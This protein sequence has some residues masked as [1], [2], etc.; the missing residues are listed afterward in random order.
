MDLRKA[1]VLVVLLLVLSAV[2][3][4][5]T[6]AYGR[7]DAHLADARTTEAADADL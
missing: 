4:Q 5:P 2:G 6:I 1:F 7:T 3:C